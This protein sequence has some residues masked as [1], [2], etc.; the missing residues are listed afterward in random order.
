[1]QIQWKDWNRFIIFMA[2]AIIAIASLT[3][4]SAE[5][6]AAQTTLQESYRVSPHQ[7]CHALSPQDTATYVSEQLSEMTGKAVSPLLG[8]TVIGWFRNLCTEAE[9]KELLPWYYQADFLTLSVVALLILALKDTA[10]APLG[11]LKK[12][13]DAFGEIVHGVGGLLVLPTTVVYFA[14]SIS[15]P[16]TETLTS[17]SHWIVPS[18]YAVEGSFSNQLSHSFVVLGQS[19]GV[20]IGLILFCAIWTFGNIVEVIVFL[21]PIVFVDTIL[22]GTRSTAISFVLGLTYINPIFGGILALAIAIFSLWCFGWAFRLLVYG[23]VYSGDWLGRRWRNTRL[24]DGGVLAFSDR[25]IPR[26]GNRL[27]GRIYPR[28]GELIFMYYPYLVLPKKLISIPTTLTNGS[29]VNVASGRLTPRLVEVEPSS[30]ALL[31]LFHLPPRYRTR[32]SLVANYLNLTWKTKT[33]AAKWSWR[34]L[35]S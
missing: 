8:V 13:L 16:I 14:D 3:F 35:L 29:Q 6:V 27:L 26:L 34:S 5:P 20:A 21:C 9:Y 11:P 4:S 25:N 23:I 12:P 22:I 30:D 32:E 31:E 2:I 7:A 33:E 10:L 24:D 19:F 18:A 28:D 17:L 15:Y 1:M